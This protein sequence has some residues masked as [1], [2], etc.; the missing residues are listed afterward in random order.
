MNPEGKLLLAQ[1]ER[2]FGSLF[3]L[4]DR[5]RVVHG[6]ECSISPVTVLEAGERDAVLARFTQYTQHRA[7]LYTDPHI[8]CRVGLPHLFLVCSTGYADFGLVQAHC[9][10]LA[11]S[12]T[13]SVPAS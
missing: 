5:C 4:L 10:K 13:V 2:M 3:T 9:M 7:A 11:V 8:V 1:R 6:E 12:I